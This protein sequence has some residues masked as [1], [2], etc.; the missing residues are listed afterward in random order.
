[1]PGESEAAAYSP[2]ALEGFQS[3]DPIFAE[4]LRLSTDHLW[5]RP[6]LTPRERALATL[7]VDV[8][9]ATL[10]CSFAAHVALAHQHGV[11]SSQVSAMLRLLGQRMPARAE[12]ASEALSI[13]AAA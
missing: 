9:G 13:A 12:Q 4:Q 10:G 7:A 5:S 3:L 6:G 8:A 11:N 1:L 2:W